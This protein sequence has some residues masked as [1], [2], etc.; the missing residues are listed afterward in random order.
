MFLDIFTRQAQDVFLLGNTDFLD[1]FFLQGDGRLHGFLGKIEG[2]NDFFFGNFI[3]TGF[4]HHDRFFGTGYEQV[5]QASEALEEGRLSQAVTEGTRAGR[6]LEDLREELRK[7]ASDRF[8]EELTE[9]R[10]QARQ[11]DENQK[12]LSEPWPTT[13]LAMATSRAP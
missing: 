3:G 4:N 11:L 6:Q 9:M 10:D 5:K 7:K 13:K 1:Q 2:F 12:K 8:S